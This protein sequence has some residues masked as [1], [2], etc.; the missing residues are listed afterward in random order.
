MR[1]NERVA[2]TLAA[3]AEGAA[4]IIHAPMTMV[5]GYALISGLKRD[6]RK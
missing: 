1:L 2:S 5:G 4:F 3:T 6:F